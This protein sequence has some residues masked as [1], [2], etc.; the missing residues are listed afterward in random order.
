MKNL[1]KIKKPRSAAIHSMYWNLCWTI[2]SPE[3]DL[4]ICHLSS[5]SS[6]T[7]SIDLFGQSFLQFESFDVDRRR[8]SLLLLLRV[9]PR[10]RHRWFPLQ[11]ADLSR[12]LLRKSSSLS[13]GSLISVCVQDLRH[14]PRYEHYE[15]VCYETVFALQDIPRVY[16]K[17]VNERS[18]LI[19][20]PCIRKC[21]RALDFHLCVRCG[22]DRCVGRGDQVLHQ[23]TGWSVGTRG[24]IL[25][26]L[27]ADEILFRSFGSRSL[28]STF[29]LIRRSFFPSLSLFLN[30]ERFNI[31][32]T[33]D[34]RFLI[35]VIRET[36]RREGNHSYADWGRTMFFCLLV[37]LTIFSSAAGL[38]LDHFHCRTATCNEFFYVSLFR[39]PRRSFFDADRLG[40]SSVSSSERLRRRVSLDYHRSR[41]DPR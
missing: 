31:A 39:R 38:R 7:A 30:K 18:G 20:A 9:H 14:L 36:D 1:E 25:L 40:S 26:W 16:G 24:E 3:W 29:S 23:S 8:S 34:D 41:R 5:S 21:R 28:S 35:P 17:C 32:D 4:D 10:H 6:L 12:F 2:N 15:D 27:H 11:S 19:Q 13:L 22:D 33:S 37:L